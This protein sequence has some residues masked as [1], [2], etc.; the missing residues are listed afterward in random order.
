MDSVIEFFK[1]SDTTVQALG[2]SAGGL[3]GVF[4]TLAVFFLIIWISDKVGKKGE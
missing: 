1:S 2:V 4:A 3:I